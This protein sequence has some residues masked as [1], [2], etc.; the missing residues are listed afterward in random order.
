MLCCIHWYSVT[1]QLP[2]TGSWM[3]YWSSAMDPPGDQPFWVCWDVDA[4]RLTSQWPKLFTAG[5]F[6]RYLG[7]L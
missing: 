4:L 6:L 7:D 1:A 5:I 3:S 2:S